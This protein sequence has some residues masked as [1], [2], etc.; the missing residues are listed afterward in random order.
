MCAVVA[1]FA[2]ELLHIAVYVHD[3]LGSDY[4]VLMVK[5]PN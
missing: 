1:R 3:H 2:I 4:A 5:P